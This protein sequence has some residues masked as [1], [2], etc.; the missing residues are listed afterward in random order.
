MGSVSESEGLSDSAAIA[1]SDTTC[2]GLPVSLRRH[3][4]LFS[5]VSRPVAYAVVWCLWGRGH[6]RC[7]CGVTSKQEVIERSQSAKENP[8]IPPPNA[9]GDKWHLCTSGWRF[10]CLPRSCLAG[11][12][13][14]RWGRLAFFS[15]SWKR[16]NMAPWGPLR[17]RAGGLRRNAEKCRAVC[18]RLGPHHVSPL[19]QDS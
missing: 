16:T 8:A 2:H 12:R 9:H 7:H 6:R 14:A 13:H 4:H 1:I 19:L 15:E 11:T 10:M 18:L 17:A 3:H 5:P